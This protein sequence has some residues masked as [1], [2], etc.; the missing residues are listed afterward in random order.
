MFIFIFIPLLLSLF[1]SHCRK[2][3]EGILLT[4]AFFSK[5]EQEIEDYLTNL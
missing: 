5:F 3:L 1:V 2:H 4:Q